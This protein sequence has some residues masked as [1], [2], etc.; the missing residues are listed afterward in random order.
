M[1]EIK[2]IIK[3]PYAFKD[4]PMG[5]AFEGFDIEDEE[6][7]WG[8]YWGGTNELKKADINFPEREDL[9]AYGKFIHLTSKQILEAKPDGVNIVTVIW[10]DFLDG[11]IIQYGNSGDYWIMLGKL[12]GF[13]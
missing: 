9:S 7:L 6:F 5:T 13:A 3:S 4:M 2:P 1:I 8:V 12:Y 11:A 10:H